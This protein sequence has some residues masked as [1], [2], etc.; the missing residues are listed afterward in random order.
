MH[1]CAHI[2]HVA[3]AAAGMHVYMPKVTINA[4][5]LEPWTLV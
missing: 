1:E 3:T 4:F 2:F 5:K